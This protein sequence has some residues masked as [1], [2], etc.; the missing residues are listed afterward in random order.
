M[1]PGPLL[2]L[3]EFIEENWV[4]AA[5]MAS[6]SEM[7]SHLPCVAI[8]PMKYR[9]PPVMR[10]SRVPA[11]FWPPPLAL[12]LMVFAAWIAVMAA[13]GLLELLADMAAASTAN[14]P[15]PCTATFTS[16]CGVPVT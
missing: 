14:G 2:L 4:M 12:A 1:L 15:L 11:I 9:L 3:L 16:P 6:E 5:V 8:S 10:H 13:I 7:Y